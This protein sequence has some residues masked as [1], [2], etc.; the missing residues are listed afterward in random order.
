MN[1]QAY[2]K[3]WVAIALV[4]AGF[5]TPAA[6]VAVAQVDLCRSIAWPLWRQTHQAIAQRTHLKLKSQL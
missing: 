1:K 5:L 2:C 4:W 6:G 3:V